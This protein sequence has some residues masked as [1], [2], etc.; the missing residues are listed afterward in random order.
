MRIPIG[1]TSLLLILGDITDQAVDA[2]VTAANESLMGGGGVD[3]AIH[4][5]GGPAILEGCREIRRS[6]WPDGLPTGE[7]VLT[8][9][10]NL[11]ARYVIHTVGP[12]WRGGNRGEPGQLASAYRNSLTLAREEQL[13]TV[14]FP[15]ISTGAFGYPVE[16]AAVV[17][18]ETV[19]ASV[20]EYGGAFDEVRFVM[21]T[22][23]DLEVYIRQA[24]QSSWYDETAGGPGNHSATRL[25]KE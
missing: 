19:V 18:L 12:I 9:A 6:L 22:K 21:F 11:P 8:T 24:E 10:G 16:H 23:R 2:V 25:T 3:G 15:S 5:R 17:A 13:R 1:R 7:A 4:R 14:A 20:R